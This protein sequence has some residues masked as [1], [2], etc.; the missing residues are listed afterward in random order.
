[1]DPN[2]HQNII[3]TTKP[4]PFTNFTSVVVNHRGLS[5]GLS[6]LATLTV[7]GLFPT[8]RVHAFVFCNLFPNN[9]S[10]ANTHKKIMPR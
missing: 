5:L 6:L 8:T 2:N 7:T 9:I 10:I 1:L 4:R 3:R